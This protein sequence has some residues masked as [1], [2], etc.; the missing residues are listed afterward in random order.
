LKISNCAVLFSNPGL[1]FITF[2]IFTAIKLN[3][4]S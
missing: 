4:D 1:K 3:E 2:L